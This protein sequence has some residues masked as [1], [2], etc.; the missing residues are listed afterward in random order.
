M[1][2]YPKI[3]KIALFLGMFFGT[4]LAGFIVGG[5]FALIGMLIMQNRLLGL[6]GMVGGFGGAVIGYPIGIICGLLIFRS[7]LKY[8]GSRAFGILGCL[9]GAVIILTL[10]VP[11]KIDIPLIWMLTLYCVITPLLGT[12]GFYLGRKTGKKQKRR[13][14]K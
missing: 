10:A 9:L 4:A 11:L 5:I 8:A 2:T 3:R 13:K 1:K 6:G 7:R 12:T 14:G